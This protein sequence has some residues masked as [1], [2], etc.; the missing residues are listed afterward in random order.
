M[1]QIVR[2]V[3][4]CVRLLF[5]FPQSVNIARFVSRGPERHAMHVVIWVRHIHLR[6]ERRIPCRAGRAPAERHR[7]RR[8]GAAR[9]HSP[10]QS[11]RQ[12]RSIRAQR[13][14]KLVGAAVHHDLLID[15]IVCVV[16]VRQVND[17]PR[18]LNRFHVVVGIVGVYPDSAR[19]VRHLLQ[20]P[21]RVVL[22]H[23]RAPDVVLRLGDPEARVILKGDV[24]SVGRGNLRDIPERIP[25]DGDRVPVAVADAKHR[26]LARN[27]LV[28]RIREK[29]FCAVLCRQRPRS[30][31]E[32]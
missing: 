25:G 4:I 28:G 10:S 24:A 8:R 13:P 9:S 2:V 32:G 12:L 26:H 27:C 19:R 3:G 15:A 11:V 16:V 5:R 7:C 20:P 29:I 31:R 30:A 23:D 18:I 22:V 17:S 1:Q 6:H 21:H 14:R